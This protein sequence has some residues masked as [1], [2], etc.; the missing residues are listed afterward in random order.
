MSRAAFVDATERWTALSTSTR[1][2]R[3]VPAAACAVE[4]GAT[5]SRTSIAGL[6]ET[7]HD[8]AAM[9]RSEWVEQYAASFAGE[10]FV[11]EFVFANPKF[12]KSGIEK[13]VA[14]LL[15]VFRGN[16]LV[17]QLKSQ[18]DP[19]ARDPARLAAWVAKRAHDGAS[20]LGGS[21]RTLEVRD[22][23]CAHARRGRV[24]FAAG[25]LSPVHGLV[26]VECR[27]ARVHVP[28]LPLEVAGTPVAYLDTNDFLNVVDQL[29]SFRDLAAYLTARA[30]LGEDVR[31]HLGGERATLEYYLLHDATFDGWTS[32]DAA[33]T[34]AAAERIE[35]T[36]QFTAKHHRDIPARFLEYVADTLAERLSTYREGLDA[37]TL[38]RFDE[39]ASRL[40]YLAM[41]EILCTLSLVGRRQLGAAMLDTFGPP[42]GPPRWLHRAVYL[43][44]DLT[45]VFVLVASHG[46]SRQ[47]IFQRLTVLLRSALAHYGRR[48]ALGIVDRDSVGFEMMLVQEFEPT[49]EDHAAAAELWQHLRVDHLRDR[50][51]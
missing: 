27:D 5:R 47:T 36:A 28:A 32:Y 30:A 20:Q 50:L 34:R 44:E 43:D 48:N 29:R 26:I 8:G 16:A 19:A 13:E 22:A 21:L 18:E 11:R 31:R 37:G 42:G 10:P 1:N 7:G 9:Q 3:T 40:R 2:T 25:S 23:W 41:Q 4:C 17:A 14:D 45:H 15:F 24:T 46:E 49:P 38:A 51:L 6:R 33:A 12:L 39:D 35:R